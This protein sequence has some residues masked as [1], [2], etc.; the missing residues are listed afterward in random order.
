MFGDD[1]QISRLAVPAVSILIAFLAYT[2]QYF[3]LHFES[4]PLRKDEVWKINIFALCIWVSYFRSCYVDPG[5]LPASQKTANSS[6]EEKAKATRRQ[7]WCRRC[8]AYKP[9]R[10]HHCKTCQR[11]IPKMD[12][13]CPWTSNCV[14]HFTFPHFFRFLFFAV[15]GMGYLE[16]LIWE[17]GSVVWGSRNLPSYLGPSLGQLCH[18]F[19]L[20]VVNSVTVLALFILL[21][22]V[23]YSV[24]F[25][26]TTIESW[27]IERHE[28]LVRR[29]RVM[30]GY[31]DAPGGQKI[32]IKKQEF[33]YDIGIFS[34]ISQAMGTINIFSWFWPFATTPDRKSGWE[35]PINEF[36]ARGVSWPPPDPDRIP[37]PAPAPS[38]STSPGLQTY[39]S[40]REE[41]EAFNRRQSD[42]MN[43][44]R[45]FSNVQRRRRFHER[46]Q[47]VDHDG[48]EDEGQPGPIYGDDSDDGEESWRNA[49]GERLRDFGVDE[50]VEFYDEDDIPLAVLMEQRRRAQ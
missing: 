14:S 33:P 5:R 9:P 1:F 2:S 36:E 25:N 24:L 30:G 23:L 49:D 18:L 31:L 44:R 3:F 26:I 27:E 29:A 50:D 46:V 42:D 13:H 34:N 10:A 4:V 6:P 11:C 35:F 21:V 17:R 38:T 39:A 47:K 7:R 40:A 19:L 48:S 22:R 20:F 41:I 43:R 8:E 37:L 16:T 15:V 28:T 45:Q 12:H 32:R